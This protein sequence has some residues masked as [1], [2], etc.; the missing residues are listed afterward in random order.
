MGVSLKKHIPNSLLAM[1]LSLFSFNFSVS[2]MEE[3]GQNNVGIF[4]KQME[5]IVDVSSEGYISP[6]CE[7]EVGSEALSYRNQNTNIM[8]IGNDDNEMHKVAALLGKNEIGAKLSEIGDYH[9]DNGKVYTAEYNSCVRFTCFNLQ[10]FLKNDFGNHFDLDFIAANVDIIIYL[11]KDYPECFKDVKSFYDKLNLAWSGN[12]KYFD[13]KNN[14]YKPNGVTRTNWFH[15]IM[16]GKNVKGHRYIQFIYNGTK[17]QQ[18]EVLKC[19]CGVN[20]RDIHAVHQPNCYEKL[21]RYIGA[22]P[23]SRSIHSCKIDN[24]SDISKL[25]KLILSVLD[26]LKIGERFTNNKLVGGG[27]FFDL[28]IF[29]KD[30]G[31]GLIDRKK[32]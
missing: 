23:D 18:R 8:I 7:G 14:I 12:G 32:K 1:L 24:D 26:F 27:G 20:L 3:N 31:S 29:Q 17:E 6:L 4:Q 25:R 30:C 11:V 19:K 2:G 10:D 16:N 28:C 21:N 9:Y 15:G 22:M 5:D 13:Y